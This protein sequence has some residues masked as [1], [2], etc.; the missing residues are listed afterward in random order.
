MHSSLACLFVGFILSTL[1]F[2]WIRSLTLLRLVY[3]SQVSPHTKAWQVAEM[4]RT[5]AD[6]NRRRGITGVIGYDGRRFLQ[7]IE[8]RTE[9]VERLFDRI[10]KD[11]RHFGVVEL[12]RSQIR[13]ISFDRWR[14]APINI[15]DVMAFVDRD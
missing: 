4:V 14:M 13:T 9:E 7:I 8:G 12:A 10:R 2:H 6:A 11:D 5:A 1:P 15:G 3:A